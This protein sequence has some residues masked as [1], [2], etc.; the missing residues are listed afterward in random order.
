M[1]II[2]NNLLYELF[3]LQVIFNELFYL[4]NYFSLS[5]TES[6]SYI[7]MSE[8]TSDTPSSQ[9]STPATVNNSAPAPTQ[10]TTSNTPATP[11]S[12]NSVVSASPNTAESL[13]T[14]TANVAVDG[15]IITSTVTAAREIARHIPGVG[16]KFSAMGAGIIA[17][18]A[19]IPVKNLAGNATKDFGNKF[20]GNFDLNAFFANV[21]NLTGNSSYDLITL[22]LLFNKLNI[23]IL[24]LRYRVYFITL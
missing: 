4:D 21:F 22:I 20:I 11:I 2:E 3:N 10:P 7:N 15:A 16:G 23:Y 18:G 14:K 17:G 19:G 8:S 5:E 1:K 9:A 13:V 6:T 24:F 12:N